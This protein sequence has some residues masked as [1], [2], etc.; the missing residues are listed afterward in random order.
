MLVIQ[1]DVCSIRSKDKKDQ[2]TDKKWSLRSK[3]KKDAV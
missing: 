1:K 2:K 3:D